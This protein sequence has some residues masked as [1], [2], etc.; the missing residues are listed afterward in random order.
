M[1]WQSAFDLV[2]NGWNNE[3]DKDED[4]DEEDCD[5]EDEQDGKD[6]YDPKFLASNVDFAEFCPADPTPNVPH[7]AALADQSSSSSQRRPDA[8]S[9]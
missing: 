7:C 9:R 2:Q 8:R 1:S 4:E 3:Y 5:E 6:E